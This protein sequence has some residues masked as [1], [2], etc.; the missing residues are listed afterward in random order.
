MKDISHYDFIHPEDRAALENLRSIPL[1]SE[2]VKM[3]MKALPEQLLHGVSMAQKIRLGAEQLPEVYNRLPPLCQRLGI[4]EPEFY[5]EMNPFPN[6]YT[7]GET[8]LFLTITSG[9]LEY[10]GDDEVLAVLAHECGHIAC[11]HVLYQTMAS[12]ILEHGASILGLPEM[13]TLPVRIALFAWMR[14]SELSADRAAALALGDPQPVVDTMIRL[15]GGPKSLTDEIDAEL[16]CQQ[17]QAYD[18]LQDSQWDKLLQSVAVIDMDHPFPAVRTREIQRWCEGEHFQRILQALKEENKTARCG[19]CG[20]P[21]RVGWKFCEGCGAQR[22]E[23]EIEREASIPQCP[24]CGHLLKAG[25]EF[26]DLC[27]EP[28]ADAIAAT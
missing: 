22:P 8:R 3:F 26:C 16:Y 2:C 13:A 12:M 6:A 24:S 9:L 21:L 7:Q 18:R 1:F 10:L 19:N 23:E 20:Q 4:A 15:S 11:H 28:V 14:R 27:G 17:A 5:L 25:W